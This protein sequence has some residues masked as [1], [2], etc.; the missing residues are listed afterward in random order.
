MRCINAY[1]GVC[2]AP[3]LWF[4][5]KMFFFSVKRVIEKQHRESAV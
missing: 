5:S 1:F 3:M 2:K 4:S